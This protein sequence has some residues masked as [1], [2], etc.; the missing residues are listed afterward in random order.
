MPG[1]KR[2]AWNS[3]PPLPHPL[4]RE[5]SPVSTLQNCETSSISSCKPSKCVINYFGS[6]GT[7]CDGREQI[8]LCEYDPTG[9]TL[10]SP[11]LLALLMR[12][13]KTTP[14]QPAWLR[15]RLLYREAAASLSLNPSCVIYPQGYC[16]DKNKLPPECCHS[17]AER[18]PHSLES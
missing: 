16:P 10:T 17:G 3:A 11:R 13:L 7:L 14:Q 8:H 4:Q 18:L 2:D 1:A 5:C 9:A 6:P 15:R 12:G